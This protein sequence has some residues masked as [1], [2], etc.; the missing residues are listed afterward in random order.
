LC[1]AGC[2]HELRPVTWRLLLR[3]APGNA[4]RRL[5]KLERLRAEYTDAVKNYFDKYDPEHASAHD[6][7]TYCQIFVDLPRTNPAM[8]LFQVW[9]CVWCV[10]LCMCTCMHAYLCVYIHTNIHMYVCIYIH[11]YVCNTYICLKYIHM[12]VYVF[13][14]IDRRHR[15][16]RHRHR[17]C[18]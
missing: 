13:L 1:W 17:H 15:H 7:V 3:Y 11:M 8:H 16:R 9:V 4:D 12:F 18:L 14:L 6:K 5:D 2:P 10:F